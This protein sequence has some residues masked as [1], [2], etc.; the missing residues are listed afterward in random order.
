MKGLTSVDLKGGSILPGCVSVS[1]FPLHI[2]FVIPNLSL[3]HLL[4][5]ISSMTSFG[6][7]LGIQEMPSE[8]STQD[9]AVFDALGSDVPKLLA[10]QVIKGSESL[11]FGG[12]DLLYDSLVSLLIP[13]VVPFPF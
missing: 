6:A 11:S 10:G 4:S 9:G 1:T 3:I 8:A 12:K 7:P 13:L 5:F 2:G